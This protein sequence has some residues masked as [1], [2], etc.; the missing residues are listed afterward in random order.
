MALPL[1]LALHALAQTS[2]KP[3]G[4]QFKN[5]EIVWEVQSNG[6]R[7]GEFWPVHGLNLVTKDTDPSA[8]GGTDI[9]EIQKS[10]RGVATAP[11]GMTAGSHGSYQ[12][13]GK[14]LSHGKPCGDGFV[15]EYG[16]V[17][18]SP[19]G[20][21]IEFTHR[22]EVGNFDSFYEKRKSAGATIFFLPSVFRN[23][24]YLSSQKEIEKVFIRR[25]TPNGKTQI[26]VVIF[27]ELVTY[28][29]AREIITGLDRKGKSETTHIYVLD[30]GPSWG[31]SCKEVN[32]D[33]KV[34]GTRNPNVVTNY[35]VFY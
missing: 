20:S 5:G 27:D 15:Y 33:A 29:H 4:E 17:S 7:V 16:I 23:G 28:D 32:G 3:T 10:L 13:Q 11:D 35:L 6:Q 34:V 22:N 24:A 30:G 21:V 2:L 14:C 31:Q 19:N 1:F 18:V 26:G 25:N 12:L 9:R 8:F